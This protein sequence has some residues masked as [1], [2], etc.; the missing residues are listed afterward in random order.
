MNAISRIKFLG[1]NWI[2]C[3]SKKLCNGRKRER[4]IEA[5]SKRSFFEN[6]RITNLFKVSGFYHFMLL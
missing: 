2:L 5:W 3:N 1:Q 4:P 6:S